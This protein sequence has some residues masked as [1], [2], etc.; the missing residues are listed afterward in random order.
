MR[1]RD[2]EKLHNSITISSQFLESLVLNMRIVRW[3]EMTDVCIDCNRKAYCL[4]PCEK[5]LIE[6]DKCPMC[7]N[8]LIRVGGCTECITGDWAKCG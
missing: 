1:N 6:H 7:Q 4:E 2:A 5:W 3:L 8:K